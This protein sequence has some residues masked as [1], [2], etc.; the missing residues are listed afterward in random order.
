[1][2]RL[3][4]KQALS[5]RNVQIH[6]QLCVFCGEY[7]ETSEHIFISCHFAQATWLN[8]A[9]W[10]GIP[11]IIA[12]GL[13]DLLT[14]HGS[15]S[16]SEKKWKAIHAVVLVA[17]WNIWKSRNDALFRQLTPNWVKML[18]EIKAMAYLWIK[19]RSKVTS[20]TW[21]DWSRFKFGD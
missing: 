19:S 13:K 3:P 6:D 12:F 4:T 11:P 21:E 18:D 7:V 9:T 15:S 17:I 14:I 1:M 16:G 10:W 20:L 8:L 2:E 5:A